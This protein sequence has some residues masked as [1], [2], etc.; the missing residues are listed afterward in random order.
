ML[1]KWDGF[2]LALAVA[3]QPFG[4]APPSE[5]AD[6][7]FAARCSIWIAFLTTSSAELRAVH[8][9]HDL[10][11]LNDQAFQFYSNDIWVLLINGQ[12]MDFPGNIFQVSTKNVQSFPGHFPLNFKP[13]LEDYPVVN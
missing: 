1:Q 6:P 11:N 4:P 9:V 13:L 3:L 2:F 7:H 12:S 8:R 5:S 10:N